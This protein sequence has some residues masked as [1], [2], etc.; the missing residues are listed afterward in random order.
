MRKVFV[1]LSLLLILLFV[2]GCKKNKETRYVN[3]D[4]AYNPTDA[5]DMFDFFDYIN[6]AQITK[7]LKTVSGS[8]NI[9]FSPISYYEVEISESIKGK[10]DDKITIIFYGGYAKKGVLVLPHGGQL[11]VINSYY[12]IFANKRSDDFMLNNSLAFYLLENYDI[13]NPIFNQSQEVLMAIQ[14]IIIR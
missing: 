7:H 11:P 14:D 9:G 10:V 3:L 2:T 5:E 12:L 13:N 8:N 6:V 1:S 4:L